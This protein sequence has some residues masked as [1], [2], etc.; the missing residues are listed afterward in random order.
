MA[1][2][3]DANATVSLHRENELAEEKQMECAESR[4]ATR[5]GSDEKCTSE[6][7]QWHY[8]RLPCICRRVRQRL[9]HRFHHIARDTVLSILSITMLWAK[10]YVI[11][12]DV[13]VYVCVCEW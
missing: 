12:D 7:R 1:Y 3:K 9:S 5:F 8:W 10:H 4:H 6:S 2:R 13:Y 11:C